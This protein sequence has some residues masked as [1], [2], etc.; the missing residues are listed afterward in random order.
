MATPV[1]GTFRL[2]RSPLDDGTRESRCNGDEV[3]TV[4][5]HAMTAYCAPGITDHEQAVVLGAQPVIVEH[6]C[7]AGCDPSRGRLL[8]PY[9]TTSPGCRMAAQR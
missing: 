9:S 5:Y 6:V 7:A 8:D 1:A 4:A 2:R 3:V